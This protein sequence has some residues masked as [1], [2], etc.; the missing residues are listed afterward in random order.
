M[1]KTLK[2]VIGKTTCGKCGKQL[3]IS[4]FTDGSRET[5]V[6]PCTMASEIKKEVKKEVK[7]ELKREEGRIVKTIKKAFGKGKGKGK[8]K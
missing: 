4:L 2:A 1:A 3:K 6:C 5:E 7:T 8:G